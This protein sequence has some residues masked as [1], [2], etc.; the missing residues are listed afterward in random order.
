MD[1]VKLMEVYN[2]NRDK[3]QNMHDEIREQNAKLK[4]APFKE[5]AAY[6]KEY[7]LKATL[8][9]IAV[10][11]LIGYIAYS[12]IT[13]PDDTAFA[14]YFFNNIGD[15]SSTELLDN[16]VEYAGIDTKK[17]DAYIDATMRYS[18]SGGDMYSGYIDIEKSMAVIA[19]KELD[20]IVGDKEAFDYY[21]KSEVF[22]DVTTILPDDLMDKFKDKLYYYTN[23]ETNETLPLGID[24][25][26]APKLQE[27]HY[28]DGMTAYFGFIVNSDSIDNAITFLRYIYEE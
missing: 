19:S 12:M 2:K 27:Y 18:A 1:E 26:D 21:S 13:A 16:F 20:V 5:K 6:F 28:Y 11:V 14:A 4:N 7:Y 3:N 24:V 23:E 10:V 15:S 8:I 22:S 25:S 17:H 9:I